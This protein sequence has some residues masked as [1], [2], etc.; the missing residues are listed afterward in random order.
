VIVTGRLRASKWKDQSG[1]ERSRLV[2]EAMAIGHD[3]NR[4]T[5]AYRRTE[6][7]TASHEDDI[8]DSELVRR[9]ETSQEPGPLVEPGAA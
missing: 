6:R 7:T 2:V 5:T 4:G 8:D 9:L 3:L 1:E